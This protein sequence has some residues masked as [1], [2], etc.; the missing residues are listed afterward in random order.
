MRWGAWPA[1]DAE[2]PPWEQPYGTL[3][4][5]AIH[6]PS[7]DARISASSFALV[8]PFCGTANHLVTEEDYLGLEL[9]KPDSGAW[10]ELSGHKEIFIRG[11]YRSYRKTHT[12]K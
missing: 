3:P 5:G 6:C 2:D 10:G 9:D 1:D 7:C 4:Y 8:C 12:V 11:V